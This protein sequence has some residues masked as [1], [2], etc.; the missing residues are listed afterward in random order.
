[1]K[2]KFF[3]VVIFIF[4]CL[5][6]L[7]PVK[8]KAANMTNYIATDHSHGKSTITMLRKATLLSYRNR[9]LKSSAYK[10]KKYQIYYVRYTGNRAYY[11]LKN[12]KWIL[13]NNTRGIVYYKEGPNELELITDKKGRL[14]YQ[15]QVIA[16]KVSLVLK[17]NAYIYNNRGQLSEGT[18]VLL[19]KGLHLTGYSVHT[20]RGTKFYLTNMG[21]IKAANVQITKKK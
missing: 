6:F 12:N 9:Y 20:I 2:K 13:A 15:M 7:T 3:S 4:V 11:G 1:M 10:G 5:L 16:T 14:V 17:R 18:I 8:A 19:R 21:W